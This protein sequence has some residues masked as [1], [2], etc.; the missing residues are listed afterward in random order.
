MEGN[1]AAPVPLNVAAI[2]WS[3]FRNRLT[4]GIIPYFGVTL[5]G[6]SQ[7]VYLTCDLRSHIFEIALDEGKGISSDM[8]RLANSLRIQ[9]TSIS[10]ITNN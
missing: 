9:S 10:L 8:R 4:N 3:P 1:T 2:Y 6:E 7:N 5:T